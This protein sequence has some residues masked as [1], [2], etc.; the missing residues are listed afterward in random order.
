MKNKS[1][2]AGIFILKRVV[3]KQ[4]FNR[5]NIALKNYFIVL[6]LFLADYKFKINC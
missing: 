6:F 1:E 5:R 3:I 2:L 4:I